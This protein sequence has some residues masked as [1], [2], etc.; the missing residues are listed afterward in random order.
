MAPLTPQKR[1]RFELSSRKPTSGTKTTLFLA[2]DDEANSP[3]V[4]SDDVSYEE[5]A[6]KRQKVPPSPI[7]P[8]RSMDKLTTF[9]D[10]KIETPTA[11]KRG[12]HSHGI[13]AIHALEI[14]EDLAME[15]DAGR[16]SQ[17]SEKDEK[18]EEQEVADALL[19]DQIST[20]DK[21]Q[22]Y[23]YPPPLPN[24]GRIRF[25]MKDLYGPEPETMDDESMPDQKD[26]LDEKPVRFINNFV[27]FLD[28]S[29]NL[30]GMGAIYPKVE[31]E[32]GRPVV[33]SYQSYN[34][35]YTRASLW[36]ETQFAWYILDRP[37]PL[38][39]TAF[40]PFLLA[41]TY[42]HLL[43][44]FSEKYPQADLVHLEKVLDKP[45]GL[46]KMVMENAQK[47]L[48]SPNPL[49][50][51]DFWAQI[52][53]V[54]RAFL[55]QGD[56]TIMPLMEMIFGKNMVQKHLSSNRHHPPAQINL[57]SSPNSVTPFI[58]SIANQ[59]F[60][61]P[62]KCLGK[63]LPEGLDYSGTSAKA[64][65]LLRVHENL[66][67]QVKVSRTHCME[68]DQETIYTRILINGVCYQRGDV[69]LV[70]PGEDS[71]KDRQAE[72]SD[73]NPEEEPGVMTKPT[74][75]YCRFLY[76]QNKG[77]FSD[78]GKLW[79][80]DLTLDAV[81]CLSC[82]FKAEEAL[83]QTVRFLE[84]PQRTVLFERQ[85]YHTSDFVYIRPQVPGPFI[86]GQISHFIPEKDRIK[87]LVRLFDWSRN[88]QNML[89]EWVWRENMPAY[90]S[91]IEEDINKVLSW[92][93][94]QASTHD[95]NPRIPHP[96]EV[97]VIYGGPPCQSFS[98]ANS[99]KRDD[100]PR[101][102]LSLTA[103]SFVEL[104]KPSYVIMLEE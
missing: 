13:Q 91:V 92:V 74:Q 32:D 64:K 76:D 69:V 25:P 102:S 41:H 77:C 103:L 65:Q 17:D 2:S 70:I 37:H 29:G 94:Q 45:H 84:K 60:I 39:Q 86:R 98:H 82:A 53:G 51:V 19:E 75:F 44:L 59:H 24:F 78:V 62:L 33:D 7:T 81:H 85:V 4:S 97:E 18:E 89:D 1:T 72:A 54:R 36:V 73:P 83:H 5:P 49:K 3:T 40:R 100:D 47:D 35:M 6:Q 68:E 96:D 15:Q 34:D 101:H 46:F 58:Y 16:R 21:I 80:E 66:E 93:H 8:T 20:K 88:P 30:N 104:Y 11:S 56:H 14:D 42:L 12:Q 28:S 26:N 71:R 48:D 50:M 95:A 38:Y 55:H 31:E 23:I 52:A 27:F 10:L 9:G 87:V 79:E 67:C 43:F 99:F 90:H 61:R 57:P 63:P 22:E